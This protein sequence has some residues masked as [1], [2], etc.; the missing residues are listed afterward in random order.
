MNTLQIIYIFFF[1]LAH[2]SLEK[3]IICLRNM[4]QSGEEKHS[5]NYQIQD[6]NFTKSRSPKA[7]GVLFMLI[8]V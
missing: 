3:T 6:T 7:G 4:E 1:S 8:I 2:A 5:P